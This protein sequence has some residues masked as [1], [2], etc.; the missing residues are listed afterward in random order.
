VADTTTDI[1]GV[2]RGKSGEPV[3]GATLLIEG[4]AREPVLTNSAGEYLLPAVSDGVLRLRVTLPG[5]RARAVTLTVPAT[6]Y[7]IT[8]DYPD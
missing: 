4:S 8:L 1:G 6:S 7:D 3:G 2:V 5:G